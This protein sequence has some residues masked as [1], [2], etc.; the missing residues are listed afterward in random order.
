MPDAR[1]IRIFLEPR[2]AALAERAGSFAM[3]EIAK[4]P[5]P[6]EDAD[7]RREARTL[8]GLLGAEAWLQPIL[9]LDLRGCCLMREA[10]G[11]AS[12]LADA[13][14][15]LQ[16]LGTTPIL[17]GGTQAQK[18]RWLGPIAE[19]KVMTAFAMTEPEAG[20][21][22]AAIA[23]TARREGSG[24]ILDGSKTLIS[25]AGIADLYTVFASTDRSKG[26]KGISCFL[27]PADAPGLRFV[28]PQVLSAP[29]PLGEIAFENC[30]VPADALLGT[31]G[32]GYGL[33]LATLD[34]LRPTVAAAACGMA[35]RAL[36]ESLA[37]V[38]QRHQFGTPLTQF[39]LVQ[40]GG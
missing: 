13:V 29:H 38:K 25:N 18:D 5:E 9:D 17:L 14:F 1:L 4:R 7:A 34:R 15:A 24:Y 11:E 19:G 23:T 21:D 32:R 36:T 27:V 8:L 16:A 22:V 30:R 12:P 10:L 33:G 40:G 39:Q 37:H 3:G 2:H 20:S 26:A 6:V 35:V 28:G 31:E